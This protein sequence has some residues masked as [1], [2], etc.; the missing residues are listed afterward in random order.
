VA[1]EKVSIDRLD[2]L[3]ARL[4]ARLRGKQQSLAELSA[5]LTNWELDLLSQLIRDGD[6]P[7]VFVDRATIAFRPSKRARKEDI[8]FAAAALEVRNREKVQN[9]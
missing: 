5:S 8:A 7:A 6:L 1:F 3:R 2:D 4:I 9:A